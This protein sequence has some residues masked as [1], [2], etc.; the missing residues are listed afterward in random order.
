MKT[1]IVYG[2][3]YGYAEECVQRLAKALNGEVTVVNAEKERIPGI[4]GFDTVIAGGSVYMG[5]VQK[6][7]KKFLEE[8]VAELSGKKLGLFL[9][10][11]L[12]ENFEQNAN[13]NFP[14]ALREK[15]AAVVCF[16][17]ELRTEKMKFMHRAITKM[18]KKANEKEGKE[19]AT[20]MPENIGKLAQ[21]MNA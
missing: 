6:G 9:C 8:N 4:S 15:A 3:T 19:G 2:S 21:I 17:G 5:Q 10:C 11:G 18:M 12:P 7:V 14:E 1:L 20:P 16:G 13:N